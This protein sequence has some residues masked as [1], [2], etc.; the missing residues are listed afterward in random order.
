MRLNQSSILLLNEPLLIKD[1]HMNIIDH[2]KYLG[3]YIGSTKCDFLFRIG[4]A[5]AAIAK[6]KSIKIT[7]GQTKLQD[8]SYLKQL[9]SRYYYTVVSSGYLRKH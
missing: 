4:L 7:E 5:W 9:V 6:V 8:Q 2:F 3:S 1:Q